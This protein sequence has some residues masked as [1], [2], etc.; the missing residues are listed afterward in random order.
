M[1]S[2]G[3]R[4]R[5][6]ASTALYRFAVEDLAT[7]HKANAEIDFLRVNY[8]RGACV[9]R[10][11]RTPRAPLEREGARGCREKARVPLRLVAT[12]GGTRRGRWL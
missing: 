8:R 4:G 7:T 12:L 9:N 3:C 6:S 1:R 11:A 2:P 5:A 10:A